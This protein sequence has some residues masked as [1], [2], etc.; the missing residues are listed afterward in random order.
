[1]NI[2]LNQMSNITLSSSQNESLTCSYT[3]KQIDVWEI[4]ECWIKR[5][6]TRDEQSVEEGRKA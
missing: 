5:E 1:M 3:H 2:N 6:R 4:E